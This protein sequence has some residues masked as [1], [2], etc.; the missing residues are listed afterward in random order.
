MTAWWMPRWQQ[1][2]CQEFH[3]RQGVDPSLTPAWSYLCRPKR[4]EA[5]IEQYGRDG[6]VALIRMVVEEKRRRARM[7]LLDQIRRAYGLDQDDDDVKV[8]RVETVEDM[9]RIARDE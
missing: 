3:E 8:Y 5:M 4:I 6:A 1:Q 7:V 9:L 2:M